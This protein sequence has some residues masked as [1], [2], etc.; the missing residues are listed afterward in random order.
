MSCPRIQTLELKIY[1]SRVNNVNSYETQSVVIDVLGSMRTYIHRSYSDVSQ[2]VSVCTRWDEGYPQIKFNSY[3][4]TC[5]LNRLRDNYKVSTSKSKEQKN[6]VV[7][8]R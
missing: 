6:S 2:Q 7:L 3:L 1:H 8:V 4:F 5:E